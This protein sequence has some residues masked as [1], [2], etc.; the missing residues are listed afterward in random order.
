MTSRILITV[1][2]LLVGLAAAMP[3]R[4]E[5]NSPPPAESEARLEAPGTEHTLDL[6]LRLGLKGFR[7]GS[8]LFGR[9]GYA[10]G[11]WLNGE[12]RPDG[13][14]F[15]GRIERD[16]KAHNF[17]FNADVD[18]WVGRALRWWRGAMDL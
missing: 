13:F 18:E 10:G 3:A 6:S 8:R 2:A 12:T 5:H 16:G 7:L 15:D 11:A 17:K 9:D 14:S 1:A 4:A